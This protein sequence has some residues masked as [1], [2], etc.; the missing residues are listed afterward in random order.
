MAVMVKCREFVD[1]SEITI[2]FERLAI[3]FLIYF[4]IRK[5][6]FYVSPTLINFFD[7]VQNVRFEE[8]S[9]MRPFMCHLSCLY[10]PFKN[11]LLLSPLCEEL[12]TPVMRGRRNSNYS[13]ENAVSIT[14]KRDFD[15]ISF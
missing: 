14:E 6:I 3:I 13:N 1:A 11:Y 10:G 5:F 15:T 4:I 2:Y 9:E 8:R 7:V 12:D